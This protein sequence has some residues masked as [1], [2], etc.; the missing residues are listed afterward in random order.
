VRSNIGMT[1]EVTLRGRVLPVGGIRMK[2]LA[3]HRAGLDT[4][5][6]P[7][8]NEKDLEDVP[9]EVRNAMTFVLVER[10]DDA[11]EAGLISTGDDVDA[12]DPNFEQIM[13]PQIESMSATAST[14]NQTHLR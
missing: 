12:A 3:A 7:K 11:I 13:S 4:V 1:G 6:L 8:R 10:I 2:I 9:A 5:I 14:E